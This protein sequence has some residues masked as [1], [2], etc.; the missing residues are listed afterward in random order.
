MYIIHSYHLIYGAREWN[1][2]YM[3]KMSASFPIVFPSVLQIKEQKLQIPEAHT[4]L[5]SPITCTY[6]AWEISGP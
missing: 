6:K 3:Y 5:L 4:W 1:I 2:V